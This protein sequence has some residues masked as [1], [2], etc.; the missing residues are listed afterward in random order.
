M[1]GHRWLRA[2]SATLES[3]TSRGRMLIRFKKTLFAHPLDSQRH[4]VSE[5]MGRF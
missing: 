1:D 2:F 3:T 4:D 5:L